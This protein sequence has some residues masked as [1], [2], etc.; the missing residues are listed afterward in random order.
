VNFVAA[1]RFDLDLAKERLRIPELWRI[2]NLP[3]EPAAR[4]GVKFC[5]PLRPDAHPSCSVYDGGKRFRDWSTGK[6]YDAIDFVGEALGLQNGEAIRKF[7]ELANGHQV[8]AAHAPVFRAQK[9]TEARRPLQL[10]ELSIP[11][12]FD[13]RRLFR[14]RSISIMALQIAVS[15]RFLWTYLDPR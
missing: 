8:A 9:K 12:Q 15:R 10:P 7:I 3:G 2:L 1:T 6:D 14:F 5:S 4:D 11:S 13:L